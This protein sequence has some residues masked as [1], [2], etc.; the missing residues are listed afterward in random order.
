M[1]KH[2]ADILRATGEY[3]VP[4]T[5]FCTNGQL[6]TEQ[7]AQACID[8]NISEVIFSVDGAS[9]ETYEHIRRG[10]KWEKLL[11]RMDLLA[12]MKKAAG[13]DH[14]R[15]RVNF[16]C[17]MHNIRELPAMVDFAADH[18]VYSLHVRH[19][20][21][22]DDEEHT[23]KD[24]MAYVRV[25][26]SLADQAKKK[27]AARGIDLF[28]PDPVPERASAPGKTCLTDGSQ[29]EAN[30]YCLLPWFQ[31]IISWKGDYR[32]CST[33]TLGNLREKTFA[34]MYTGPQMQEIRRKMLWRP[35]EACSWNCHEEAY[36][37]PDQVPEGELVS[38]A[39]SSENPS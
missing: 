39:A 29:L 11:E 26:N 38:I 34:E 36:D 31:A 17:M 20:L 13:V 3:K 30:P 25:F 23:C 4:F 33:H 14:P 1:N 5:S 15:I 7:V 32:V 21:A 28:L 27:A 24:E 18:G 2:F 19:L 22:Y 8:A 10:G 9:K 12:S 6:L 37:V 16:T 35:K